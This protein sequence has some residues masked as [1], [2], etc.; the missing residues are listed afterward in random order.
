MQPPSMTTWMTNVRLPSDDG[1]AVG[2][3]AT[4]LL[5]DYDTMVVFFSFGGH[6]WTRL[7]AQVYLDQA[8]FVR[9]GTLVVQLLAEVE[10]EISQCGAAGCTRGRTPVP[11]GEKHPHEIAIE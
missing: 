7:S 5:Q 11:P 9:F 10:H 1:A 6:Q 2:E 8:D 3:V 4:R